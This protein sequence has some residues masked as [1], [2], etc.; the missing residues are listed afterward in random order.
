MN[1]QLMFSYDDLALSKKKDLLLVQ[2]LIVKE[3]KNCFRIPL[4]TV[5]CFFYILVNQNKT[6]T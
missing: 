1:N 3:W 4:Y 6:I 5:L 2:N